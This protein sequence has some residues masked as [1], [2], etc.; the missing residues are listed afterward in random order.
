MT[1]LLATRQL[2]TRFGTFTEYMFDNEA[3]ALVMGDVATTEVI[4]RIH[5]SCLSG[6]GFNSVE[7]Q[8]REEMEESQRIIQEAGKGIVVW[9]EQEGKGNGHL[10]VM[11][12][13]ALKDEGVAQADAYE[14]LGF[15]K[16]ARSFEPAAE[17]LK[18]LS[19][20]SIVLLS[21]S[22]RKADELKKHGVN[23]AGLRSLDIE[24]G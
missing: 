7:C 11:Q 15:S 17:V 23:V 4:T 20:E 22:S 21:G 12:T 5:S 24:I 1:N 9:L 18:Y 13:Q 8:C 19:V 6:H 16:D 2:K 10:A 3:I 14:R